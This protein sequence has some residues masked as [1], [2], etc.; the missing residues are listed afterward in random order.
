MYSYFVILRSEINI[1]KNINLK[2]ISF[3]FE[4]C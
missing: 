2:S 1:E 4:N 3:S